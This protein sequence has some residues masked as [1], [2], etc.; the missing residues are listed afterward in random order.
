MAGIFMSV[1]ELS[2]GTSNKRRSWNI[3]NNTWVSRTQN[4]RTLHCMSRFLPHLLAANGFLTGLIDGK[5]DFTH[6]RDGFIFHK[7]AGE[8]CLGFEFTQFKERPHL[9]GIL[10]IQQFWCESAERFSDVL[11]A[12][13]A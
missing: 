8:L 2:V 1:P 7:D 9:W 3:V 5:H 4:A 11:A 13:T 10:S 12:F 6:V